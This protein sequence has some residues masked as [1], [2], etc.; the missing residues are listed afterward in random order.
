MT[1]AVFTVNVMTTAKNR[2]KV[3]SKCDKCGKVIVTTGREEES[4]TL[5]ESDQVCSCEENAIRER[6]LSLI[7]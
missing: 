3:P 6:I 7:N 5:R 1:V 2:L 4:S